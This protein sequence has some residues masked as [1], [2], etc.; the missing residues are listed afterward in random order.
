[1]ADASPYGRALFFEPIYRLCLAKECHFVS[2]EKF[3]IDA[4][5]HQSYSDYD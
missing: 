5:F 3:D 2:A 4:L 1:M